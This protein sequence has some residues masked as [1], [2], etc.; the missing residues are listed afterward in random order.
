M[1]AIRTSIV[2]SVLAILVVA[3]SS[4]SPSGS[5]ERIAEACHDKDTGSG[6]PHDCHEFSESGA[7]DEQCAE[8]EDDCL[9][10]CA[11]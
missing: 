9:A 1:T 7:T 2:L 3:C 10:G 8:K 11:K 6:V 4:S 5:C